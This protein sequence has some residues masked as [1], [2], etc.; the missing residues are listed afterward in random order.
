PSDSGYIGDVK[1]QYARRDGL[2]AVHYAV[3]PIKPGIGVCVKVDFEKRFDHMQQ[4]SG[5]HLLSAIFEKEERLET[6]SWNLGVDAS[7]IELK[8]AKDYVI[9]ADKLLSIENRCNELILENIPMTVRVVDQN[10]CSTKH[11]V[12]EDYVGG[13]IRY[14][15]IGTA[16]NLLDQNACCG[17]HVVNTAQLQQI[18]LAGTDRIRGGN[19]RV[20]FYVGQRICQYAEQSLQRD[21]KLSELLS[22]PPEM[23]CQAVERTKRQ[24]K[25]AL[26]SLASLRRQLA[27]LAAQDLHRQ[28]TSDVADS[29]KPRSVVYHCEDGDGPYAN[30]VGNELGKLMRSG[31]NVASWVA[32]IASGPKTEGGAVVIAGSGE[33]EIH[34]ALD[35]LS[36]TIGACKGG[37]ARG[38]WQGKASS[39]GKLAK[40][41]L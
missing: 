23:H 8:T 16:E 12:P 35:L 20:F 39:F 25:G 11:S 14:I 28:L 33:G 32:V 10:S 31:S 5:Q 22:C 21:R 41:S 3:A 18:K 2:R 9:G 27:P 24:V 17:T 1:V 34:Y 38:I 30:A 29:T 13:V 26:K 40:F 36:V 37:F 4:H 6:V 19:T 7:H 15:E